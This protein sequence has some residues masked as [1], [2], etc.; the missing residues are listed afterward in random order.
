MKIVQEL[1]EIFET[2]GEQ[3][4]KAFL[5]IKE[6]KD[7]GVPVVGMYCAYFPTEL[8]MAVGAIPVG[9][10]SFSDETV[11][12]AE[13]EMPKTMCPLVKSSYGFALEDKC[14]FLHFADLV[15]GETTCDG[16]KKM[17]EMLAEIKP[18]FVMELPNSQSER[19]LEFWKQ[20]VIRTKEY[21]EEF[22]H[23]VITNQM[24][25]DAV[26]LNNQIRMSLKKLCEVMKLDPA[27]VLG[28][29]IQKMVQGSKY[30]FDF[31]N[32]PEIVNEVRE[33]ILKE[34]EEGKRLE[35]RPRILVT[36]CPIG[37][38]SMKIIRAIED[39][40]GV[41]VA[42]ENC[43]GVRTLAEMVDETG[44]DI[45]FSI[46]RKYLA[47][48]CSIMTPNDNRI[49]LLGSIMDE[50]HVDGVVEMILNGCHS[51]GA[52]STYIR[53]FVNEEKH[54]PYI[55]VD[56][57][58]S[59]GDIAQITT[60][61]AAFVEMLQA[62]TSEQSQVDINYCYKILLSG[63][64][65]GRAREEILK[66]IWKYTGIP[67]QIEN[68][69]N[70]KKL[71]FGIDENVLLRKEKDTKSFEN[72]DIEITGYFVPGRSRAL[73]HSLLDIIAK[74]YK[75][76]HRESESEERPD[77]LWLI[78]E[79]NK[80][81]K[82]LY[83]KLSVFM[84]NNFYLNK[85]EEEGVFVSSL[86]GME[87]RTL[88]ID[89]LE[90]KINE[91]SGRILVGNGF[92][93]SLNKGKTS[94]TVQDELSL[95]NSY[96]MIQKMRTRDKIQFTEVVEESIKQY[97][98]VKI[99]LQ[100]FLENSIIHGLKGGAGCITLTASEKEESIEFLIQDNGCGINPELVRELN[101]IKSDAG[102]GIKNTMRRLHLYYEGRA[103]VVI[104]SEP[105]HGTLVIIDV[106]KDWKSEDI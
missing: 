52:E 44:E 90:T 101:D 97:S 27:P 73:V 99:V 1:P 100:P 51:T 40:G 15:I 23:V 54:L 35:K 20:E 7:K 50:Y 18:V 9:L 56:T 10:C 64:A 53:K 80:S 65:E 86:S 42:V 94:F 67:L 16:K 98:M 36:G 13:R 24:I 63:I 96:M 30:R 69:Q 41:V 104:K 59:T 17:Y 14:P 45:Y 6:Y 83:Q 89:I 70:K 57:D 43:S 11:K 5:E 37:G 12:S 21:L 71:C 62:Q 32:T 31:K 58:Y 49:Q 34:Y 28:E 75:V 25:R 93:E 85:P 87:G 61:L 22:F 39:N 92:S 60:R 103:S 68:L 29:D 8:A 4:R 26:H 48:G 66:E 74:S 102:H 76:M 47:T 91:I 106:P 95:A 78:T 55:V 19:S 77:Y 33:K 82:E 2:F 88:L 81:A 3:R 46:A 79:N 72:G 38:D 105:G 84:G